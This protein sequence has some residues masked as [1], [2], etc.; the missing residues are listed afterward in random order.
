MIVIGSTALGFETRTV[1]VN[2]PPGA[3]SVNGL[4]TFVTAI[5]GCGSV[6]DS[7][8]APHADAAAALFASPL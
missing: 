5:T 3:I 6:T 4:A 7:P 1:N 2:V 8:G